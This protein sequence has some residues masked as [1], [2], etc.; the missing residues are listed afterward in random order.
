MISSEANVIGPSRGVTA[1]CRRTVYFLCKRSA[2]QG[3]SVACVLSRLSALTRARRSPDDELD[4][5]FSFKRKDH[6]AEEAAKRA[7]Q[8]MFKG[9]K[10]ILATFDTDS[11]S[12][13]SPPGRK[14]YTGGSGGQGGWQPPNWRDW[15]RILLN[16]AAGGSKALSSI[17]VFIAIFLTIPLLPRALAFIL[18]ILKSALG[19][20]GRAR[21]LSRRAELNIPVTVSDNLG[22]SER[23]VIAKYGGDIDSSE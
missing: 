2:P 3:C 1:S 6:K 17:F 22:A 15:R 23:A 4:R 13:G 20:E 5:G 9:Q 7:L 8:G 19:L 11:G 10:D 18:S 21:S 16:R 12:G 14:K